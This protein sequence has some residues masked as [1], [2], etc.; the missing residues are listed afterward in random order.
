MDSHE[1]RPTESCGLGPTKTLL[2]KLGFSEVR[3][4][5]CYSPGIKKRFYPGTDN[6]G[7]E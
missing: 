4:L 1:I 7:L 6:L 3:L 2:S 5:T